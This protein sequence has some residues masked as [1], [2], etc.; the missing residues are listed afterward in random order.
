MPHTASE[1][2]IDTLIS[3]MKAATISFSESLNALQ[4]PQLPARRA[5]ASK[6]EIV[7]TLM[8]EVELRYGIAHCDQVERKLLHVFDCMT[9]DDLQR[10]SLS[11]FLPGAG[12]AE[13][14]SLV[15]SLTVHETYFHRDKEQLGVFSTEILPDLIEQKQRSG[16]RNLRIWSAG[17]ASGEETY[18]LAML[19]LLAMKNAGYAFERGD[20][21][22]I[23]SSTWKISV[24][25]SDISSQMI[26]LCKNASYSMTPMG[27]FRTMNPQL[28]NFFDEVKRRPETVG[29][30]DNMRIKRCV[31]DLT[32][33]RRHNLL[34]PLIEAQRFDC[35]ICRNVMIYFSTES[36]KLVQ[37]HLAG[38]LSEGGSIMLGATDLMLC[39]QGLERRQ[40][41]GSFWYTRNATGEDNT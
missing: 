26:R 6:H 15:E 16:E 13:W 38:S 27:P 2:Y 3:R 39:Q 24:L 23:P 19:T 33:F 30:A 31:T 32:R 37:K 35:I 29:A 12:E 21:S 9:F 40:Q 11:M 36:K 41:H 17:C 1:A 34:E 18:N 5:M 10:W 28:W 7:R 22:I 25:G 14:L 8:Q 20:G 4:Q